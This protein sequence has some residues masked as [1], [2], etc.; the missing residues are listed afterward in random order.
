M[1]KVSDLSLFHVRSSQ[2]AISTGYRLYMGNFKKLLGRTWLWALCFAL[3]SALMM[4]SWLDVLPQWLVAMNGHF[5]GQ[6]DMA[7]AL[8]SGPAMGPA[9]W[10]LTFV[11][12]L[13]MV[14]LLAAAFALFSE[15]QQSDTV[16]PAPHW[17]GLLH[18]Q[19]GLRALRLALWLLAISAV[20]SLAIS[21]LIVVVIIAAHPSLMLVMT[22]V[23]VLWLLLMAFMLPLCYTCYKYMLTPKSKFL[24]VL[25]NTYGTG[26]RHWG[27]LFSVALLTGIVTMLLSAVIMLPYY[28]LAIALTKAQTGMLQGDPLGMPD[29]MGW[30]SMIV[31]FIA[32]F[33]MAYLLLSTLFP[34][35]YLYGSIEQE[36]EE[37]HQLKI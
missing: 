26:L 13:A 9:Y 35:Y 37:R 17:Y 12:D 29:Y 31:F 33:I 4:R 36:Q 8:Q 3:T 14:W 30:M 18:G 23:G 6:S 7:M 34:F 21:L 32:A 28:I 11:Y 16:A 24:Q 19:M 20:A 2:A 27:S 15:H 22:M 1:N 10:V 25:G 5:L